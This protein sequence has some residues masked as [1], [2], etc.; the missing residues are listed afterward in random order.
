[1]LISDNLR[2]R[3]NYFFIQIL[4][5]NYLYGWNIILEVQNALYV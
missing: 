1:M 2:V 3:K 5:G 4:E